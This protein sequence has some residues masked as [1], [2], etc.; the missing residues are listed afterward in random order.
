TV[1]V[2]QVCDPRDTVLPILNANSPPDVFLFSSETQSRVQELV[3]SARPLRQD[4][5]GM[6]LRGAHYPADC[7][8]VFVRNAALKQIAHGIYKDELRRSPCE[9]L[10][11]LLRNEPQ[12]EP[13]FVRVSLDAPEPLGK[14]LSITMLAAR[15]D[16]D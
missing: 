3:H 10:S 16:L 9:R 4:L 15:A 6:P 11:Q 8:D 1:R 13:L 2:S 5:E 14:G 7:F 12:V